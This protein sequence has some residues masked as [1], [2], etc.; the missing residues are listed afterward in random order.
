M[1]HLL[2]S[3]LATLSFNLSL[4]T[5][6]VIDSDFGIRSV[7]RKVSEICYEGIKIFIFEELGS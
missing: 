3:D 4:Q 6:A 1:L 2:E 7:F 5:P